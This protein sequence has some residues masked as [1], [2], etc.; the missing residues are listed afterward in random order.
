MLLIMARGLVHFWPHSLLQA[1]YVLEGK[2]PIPV[3][4]E[5]AQR[6][7]IPTEQLKAAGYPV[8]LKKTSCPVFC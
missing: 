1:D 5:I 4:G 8:K 3:I 7:D 2:D 6:E